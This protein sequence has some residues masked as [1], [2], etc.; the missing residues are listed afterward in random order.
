MAQPTT[1]LYMEKAKRGP[2]RGKA[3]HC[4]A[5]PRKPDR[6]THE[7]HSTAQHAHTGWFN[8]LCRSPLAL[9]TLP[10]P[11]VAVSEAPPG[12]TPVERPTSQQECITGDVGFLRPTLCS[13]EWKPGTGHIRN[14]MHFLMVHLIQLIRTDIHTTAASLIPVH[15]VS[16]LLWDVAAAAMSQ[17]VS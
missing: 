11:V 2:T 7:A 3:H 8:F 12:R 4:A 17:L 10:V 16:V 5:D 9:G 15:A 14:V 13:E 1:P 6:H